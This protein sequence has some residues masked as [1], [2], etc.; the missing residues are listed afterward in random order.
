MNN[1]TKRY[2]RAKSLAAGIF[3]LVS[4]LF[5]VLCVGCGAK[6]SN[7]RVKASATAEKQSAKM[8]GGAM[9]ESAPMAMEMS[10]DMAFAEEPLLNNNGANAA[11][12]IFEAESES[13]N[14]AAVSTERKL[15]YTASVDM[16]VQNLEKTEKSIHNWVKEWGGYVSYTTYNARRLEISARIPT[17]KFQT[18]LDAVSGFGDVKHRSVSSEDVTEQFYDTYARLETRKILRSRLENYLKTSETMKD[19]I[20]V[21]KELNNVQSDIESME[22]RFRRLS[23]RI[24]YATITVSASLPAN[25]TE[26]GFVYPDLGYKARELWANTV[27]FFVS[28]L[29]G[30]FYVILYGVPLIAAAALV[31]WLCF[32][33]I[34][35]LRKLFT[36]LGKKKE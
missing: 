2:G 21:E 7:A 24:D 18:A 4:F 6:S 31:Y 10:A 20:A 25:T 5:V 12:T 14:T 32:G 13:S 30:I 35:L 33:R 17:A 19:L 36:R 9:Y 26:R 11:E 16:Q 28:F 34:G 23:N 3:V 27:E 1:K 8:A 15:V 22:S 29:F